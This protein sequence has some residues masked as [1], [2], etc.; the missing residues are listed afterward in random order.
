MV[1]FDLFT[2]IGADSLDIILSSILTS[3]IS[4][5]LKIRMVLHG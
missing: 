3:L 5:R 4:G 1:S 2:D